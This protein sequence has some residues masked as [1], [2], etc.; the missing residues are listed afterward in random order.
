MTH[1]YTD[2]ID[3]PR[4]VTTDH[5]MSIDDRAAQFAPY[6][7]LSGHRDIVQQDETVADAKTEIDREITIEYSDDI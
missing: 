3:L 6:A 7:T 5:P 2:I 1:P 4:P